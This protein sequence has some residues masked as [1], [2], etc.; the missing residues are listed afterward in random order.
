VN[1]NHNQAMKPFYYAAIAGL[2]LFTACQ[3]N[4]STVYNG[5]NGDKLFKTVRTSEEI[6]DTLV[7]MYYFNN[8]GLDSAEVCTTISNS[9]S[10]DLYSRIFEYDADG[11]LAK[12]SYT[13]NGQI[14]QSYTFNRDVNGRIVKCNVNPAGSGLTY[15]YAYNSSNQVIADTIYANDGQLAGY[16]TYGYDSK[17][18][19]VNQ[20]TFTGYY[21][22]IQSDGTFIWKFDDKINPYSV[23]GFHEALLAMDWTQMLSPNNATGE[24]AGTEIANIPSAYQYNSSGYPTSYSAKYLEGT[25]WYTDKQ[26]F[27]YR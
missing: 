26:E 8:Q 23:A 7:T 22:P 19:Q 12:L 10:A 15:A 4:S 1:V 9:G 17:G 14:T 18:N 25:T 2:A 20:E 27:Y 13:S 5:N 21:H 24:Y 6:G 3:K 16:R 11:K